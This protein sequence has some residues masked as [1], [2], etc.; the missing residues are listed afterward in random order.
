MRK[1]KGDP[2][3]VKQAMVLAAGLGTRLKPFTHEKP[4]P[5]IEVMGQPL[6][7]YAFQHLAALGVEKAI[8]NTHHLPDLIEEEVSTH[9]PPFEVAFSH[10]P[11]LLGTGGGI[12]KM[13]EKLDRSL[14]PIL[15]IN[16]DALIDL[17]VHA[18]LASHQESE[19]MAT[20]VVKDVPDAKSYGLIGTDAAMRVTDFAGRNTPQGPVQK[21][22]MFCGVHLVE[23]RFFEW[24]PSK[25]EF[26]V[27]QIVY[28]ALLEAGERVFG[29]EHTRYF[30]DVGTPDRHLSANLDLLSKKE[31]CVHLD[32]FHNLNEKEPGIWI[33]PS[34]QVGADVKMHGP[35][36]I[37]EGAR[38]APGVT[39]GPGVVIGK[40]VTVD[41]ETSIQSSVFMQGASAHQATSFE[42]TIASVH[43]TLALPGEPVSKMDAQA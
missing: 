28:P 4:K 1:Q 32:M 18:L 24:M 37:Q 41:S 35:V 33:H 26:C 8:V 25:K 34:A 20:I 7:A 14:G 31:H 10:E 36:F 6:L 13:A 27:N 11:E 22:F 23:P 9:P 17:N 29:F 38:I 43:H 2:T 12:K 3:I 19:R 30:C 21:Q 16:A 15:I 5:L 40:D 39:L 42:Q